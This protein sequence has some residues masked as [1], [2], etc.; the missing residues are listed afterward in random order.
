MLTHSLEVQFCDIFVVNKLFML[1]NTNGIL[2]INM[3]VYNA[4]S[5]GVLFYAQFDYGQTFKLN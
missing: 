5:S 2:N 4:H 3:F 1:Q